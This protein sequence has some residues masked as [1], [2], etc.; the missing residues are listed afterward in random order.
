M[1][2][3]VLRGLV[4]VLAL[5][6]G[7]ALFTRAVRYGIRMLL[8]TAEVTV[9]SG[10]VEVSA[11]RGDLTGLTEGRELERRARIQR[12]RDGLL[13]LFWFFW[14]VIPITAGWLP[15]AY[16]LAAPLWLLPAVPLRPSDRREMGEQ[17]R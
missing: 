13:S 16:A 12:R 14:L 8:D 9:V 5:A 11:R 3:P 1:L 17:S 4:M 10:K 2:E 7:I 15:S 6:G